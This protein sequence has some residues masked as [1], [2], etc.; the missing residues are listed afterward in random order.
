MPLQSTI[1]VS[2]YI[3]IIEVLDEIVG[4]PIVTRSQRVGIDLHYIEFNPSIKV[5]I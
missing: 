3:C 5:E 4:A 2:I 1:S